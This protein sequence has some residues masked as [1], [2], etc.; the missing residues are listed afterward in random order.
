MS[1]RLMPLFS[2]RWETTAITCNKFLIY[3]FVLD[4]MYTVSQKKFAIITLANVANSSTSRNSC[5]HA[6]A[7]TL[8]ECVATLLIKKLKMYMHSIHNKL[9][10]GSRILWY[11]IITS[12]MQ[13]YIFIRI[14]S[15]AV[16]KVN[17]MIWS[18]AITVIKSNRFVLAERMQITRTM[19]N[20]FV[21]SCCSDIIFLIQA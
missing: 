15:V 13:N 1:S 6:I 7:M 5:F 14:T 20:Q 11:F 17:S 12:R 21:V 16:S 10:S 2:R 9:L 3:W 18:A 8:M 19:F 4:D